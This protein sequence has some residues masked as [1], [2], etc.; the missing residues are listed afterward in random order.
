MTG[1]DVDG[2]T[3]RVCSTEH[4]DINNVFVPGQ[5]EVCS[6]INCNTEIF[7]R[8]RLTCFRC[9]GEDECDFMSSKKEIE[10]ENDSSIMP[11]EAV[12]CGLFSPNDQCYS[13]IGEGK[14][15]LDIDD[16]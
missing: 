15:R 14:I 11:L 3:H 4:K 2:Y 1:L 8:N 16:L 10:I 9:N 13:Y 6:E 5:F 12:P 7:P